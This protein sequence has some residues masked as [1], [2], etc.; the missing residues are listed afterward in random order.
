MYKFLL[1]LMKKNESY[2]YLEIAD[3]INISSFILLLV[4][5]FNNYNIKY[6]Y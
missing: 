1:D 4:Y 6:F 2:N 3:A 5:L